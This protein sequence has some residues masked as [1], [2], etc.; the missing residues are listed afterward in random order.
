MANRSTGRK[1]DYEWTGLAAGAATTGAITTAG[2]FQ[3]L[4]AINI[5]TTLYRLR[6]EVLAHLTTSVAANAVK[7]LGIGI[8][9]VSQD[10][11]SSGA[12]AMAKPLANLSADWIWHGFILL[13]R[14]TTTETESAGLVSQRLTIDSKA[15]R[16]MKPNQSLVLVIDPV[17]L[18]GSETAE[19][20]FGV[21]ALFGS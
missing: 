8:K 6:G 1:T 9:V 17:N 3:E 15:M 20:S 18:A 19:V 4:V 16:R 5:S 7:A 21:R 11:V 10:A 12:G 14:N 13:T 2:F